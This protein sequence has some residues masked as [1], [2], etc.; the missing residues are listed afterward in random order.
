MAIYK[1]D[2]LLFSF[3]NQKK[4]FTEE[5]PF[6]YGLSD[7]LIGVYPDK[8]ERF[9]SGNLPYPKLYFHV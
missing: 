7:F 5:E 1:G 4:I 3:V 6:S 8:L 2:L 9:A